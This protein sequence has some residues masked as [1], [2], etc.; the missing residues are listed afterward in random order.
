M[1]TPE[2][3]LSRKVVSEIAEPFVVE[4]LVQVDLRDGE[5]TSTLGGHDHQKT[6]LA[7]NSMMRGG[8]VAVYAPKVGFTCWPA[9]L[10]L[11]VVSR[12]EN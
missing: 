12:L 6:S 8:R 10:N 3:P 7:E 2:C 5:D 1:L 11:A 9:G 4:A